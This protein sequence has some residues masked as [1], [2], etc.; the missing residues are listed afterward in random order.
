MSSLSKLQLLTTVQAYTFGFFVMCHWPVAVFKA[1]LKASSLLYSVQYVSYIVPVKGQQ[2][3]EIT[4]MFQ[5]K[6]TI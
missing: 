6:Q 5:C 3:V 1:V 2:M 4:Y